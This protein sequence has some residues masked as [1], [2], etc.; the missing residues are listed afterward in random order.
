V[1]ARYLTPGLRFL[2]EPAF[3]GQDVGG[4]LGVGAGLGQDAPVRAHVL[5]GAQRGQFQ[6]VTLQGVN[7]ALDHIPGRLK[8]HRFGATPFALFGIVA[9]PRL[10]LRCVSGLTLG[11]SG[12]ASCSP[13]ARP[14]CNAQTVAPCR[15]A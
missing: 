9:P 2:E 11:A 15:P 8:N 13:A 10:A 5:V 3:F 1:S 4:A 7:R 12:G 14:V 6:A